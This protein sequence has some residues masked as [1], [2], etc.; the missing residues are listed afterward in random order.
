MD[1]T[2]LENSKR[3]L[4]FAEFLLQLSN[5]VIDKDKT[6]DQLFEE[7][8]VVLDKHAVNEGA[9][10]WM[11]TALVHIVREAAEDFKKM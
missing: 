3:R 8:G 11:R 5:V 2:T 4:V 10:S 9:Q 6:A 7:I 1:R